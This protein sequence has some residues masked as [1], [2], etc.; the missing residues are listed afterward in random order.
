M[1]REGLN[2]RLESAASASTPIRPTLPPP[3]ATVS[4]FIGLDND[5]PWAHCCRHV[6]GSLFL[7]NLSFPS[8]ALA[9]AEKRIE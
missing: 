9:F 8:R 7:A 1:A 6:V 2:S 5:S 3:Q 4:R